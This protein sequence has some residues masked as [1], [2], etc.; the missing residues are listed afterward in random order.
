M[1]LKCVASGTHGVSM[2]GTSGGIE[3]GVAT[4][5]WHFL[6]SWYTSPWL[7][8]TIFDLL[9]TDLLTQNE[10][11]NLLFIFAHVIVLHILGTIWTEKDGIIPKIE[12]N[13][14]RIMGSGDIGG[15]G[16]AVD[17]Y[18]A[19]VDRLTGRWNSCKM[20]TIWSSRDWP[21]LD[22]AGALRNCKRKK[23]LIL[24]KGFY[25]L[26]IGRISLFAFLGHGKPDLGRS[27]EWLWDHLCSFGSMYG[28]PNYIFYGQYCF[29]ITVV[30][31]TIIHGASYWWRTSKARR[32]VNQ[33]CFH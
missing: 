22:I 18:A 28:M 33:T 11:E 9:N 24:I 21:H 7:C 27:S 2:I 15:A 5:T 10:H 13:G 25:Q 3:R 29:C 4:F 1:T 12:K 23:W 26:H 17:A 8:F 20:S 19:A 6:W 30:E 16:T 32:K 31:V 14:R